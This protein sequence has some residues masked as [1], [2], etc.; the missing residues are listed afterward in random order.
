M[1]HGGRGGPKG[2][3]TRAPVEEMPALQ[4][5]KAKGNVG[6]S[7]D[8]EL[9]AGQR[10]HASSLSSSYCPTQYFPVA[11]VCMGGS[12]QQRNG[13]ENNLGHSAVM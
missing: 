3:G 11:S 12:S 8:L 9:E 5:S 2:L 13:H 7:S 10:S 4:E 6:S 1:S